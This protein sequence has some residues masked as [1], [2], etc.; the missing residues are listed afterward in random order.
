MKNKLI[1]EQ[2]SETI[3]EA[4][5]S[6]GVNVNFAPVLDLDYGNKTVLG[7]T[8]RAFTSDPDLLIKHAKIFIDAHKKKHIISYRQMGTPFDT[9]RRDMIHCAI[10]S[11]I[12][13]LCKQSLC[14]P[15]TK[16]RPSLNPRAVWVYRPWGYRPL[17]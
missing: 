3:S 14:Q 15:S 11:L 9:A 6:V 17:G 5:C 8:Q 1:T 16:F 12:Y 7:K 4:L 10:R 13:A 2:F